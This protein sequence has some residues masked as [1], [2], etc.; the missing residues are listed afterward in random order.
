MNLEPRA[1]SKGMWWDGQYGG[2]VKNG[3]FAMLYRRPNLE[4]IGLFDS[5]VCFPSSPADK[6]YNHVVH[7]GIEHGLSNDEINYI[8][9][10]IDHL[11]PDAGG[12]GGGDPMAIVS[13]DGTSADPYIVV[14]RADGTFAQVNLANTIQ[15]TPAYELLVNSQGK[16]NNPMFNMV[17]GDGDKNGVKCTGLNVKMSVPTWMYDLGGGKLGGDYDP[18]TGDIFIAAD[19][20]DGVWMFAWHIGVHPDWPKYSQGK[21]QGNYSVKVHIE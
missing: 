21:P 13:I 2:V 5:I 6:V 11:F 8:N 19:S 1:V 18:D 16:N 17:K 10:Q 4:N 14:R 15:N 9:S 7:N 12:G 20:V 3:T